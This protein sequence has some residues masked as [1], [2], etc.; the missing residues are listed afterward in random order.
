[1]AHQL[2]TV[3]KQIP[4]GAGRIFAGAKAYFYA[5]GTTTPQ[6]TYSDSGLTTPN[7]NPVVADSEGVF[8]PIYLDPTLVYKLTLRTSA[9]VLIYTVDPVNDQLL[10]Q[11]IIGEYLY[12]RTSAEI[13]A[14]V[15]PTDYAFPSGN[16]R[17][18][19]ADPTGVS[20]SAS[21]V[22]NALL[23]N[24]RIF[25][26]EGLYTISRT[27]AVAG[28][29]RAISGEEGGGF[30]AQATRIDFTG[31]G[32]LFSSTGTEFPSLYI[33]HFGISGGSG[34]GSPCIVSTR[35]QSLFE[36]LHMEG[37]SGYNNPGIQLSSSTQ[38]SWG[39]S[40]RHCKWVAPTAGGNQQNNYTGFEISIN[41]GFVE[42]EDVTAIAGN[43]GIEILQGQ[44]IRLNRVNCNRQNATY[45]SETSTDGQAAIR[46]STSWAGGAGPFYKP[47]VSIV[48][49]YLEACTNEIYVESCE[50][51]TI[52]N[53]FMNDVGEGTSPS[54]TLLNGD[55]QNVEIRNN[56][57]LMQASGAIA[58]LN[59]SDNKV[60]VLNNYIDCDGGGGALW[61]STT[62]RVDYGWNR[63]INGS[64]SDPNNLAIDIEP[65][66]G[67][68]TGT[69][70]G[71]TTSPTA[72]I[73]YSKC[74]G[75][76]N[77]QLPTL[78]ATSNTTACTIT[79]L[80]DALLPVTLKR[81]VCRVVDNGTT[82]F[83]M[84]SVDPGVTG[85]ITLGVGPTNT[86]FTNA[87]TKGSS[88]TELSYSLD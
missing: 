44:A 63:V 2:F 58:I 13:S 66:R 17:R 19:G 73:K 62:E 28:N 38:G 71:C 79:G 53:N 25:F 56:H 8:P 76:V 34:D 54:I 33:G 7:A 42:L 74:A 87:G 6:N 3:P 55:A 39:T 78:T 86:T 85:T 18:Y 26:P 23:C 65:V 47:A 59:G 1:M 70:T 69:L 32:P 64:L 43:I 80:P 5:T 50:S 83:G 72:T 10:S 24:Q 37:S 27:I 51:L 30:S 21:A 20:D 4:L 49:C 12:P 15:T 36:F 48:G 61:L 57:I 45:S 40:I 77:I 11:A 9:D 52:E 82:D 84:A 67:E 16:V 29:V 35:P 14:G 41:G 46:I 31:T 22:E 68:F 75:I 60:R 88:L 81:M